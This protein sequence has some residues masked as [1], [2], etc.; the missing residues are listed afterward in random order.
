MIE[1][2]NTIQEIIEVETEA[3]KVV[4]EAIAKANELKQSVEIEIENETK[5]LVDSGKKEAATLLQAARISSEEKA[6]AFVAE[7]IKEAELMKSEAE[8]NISEVSDYI[9]H[10]LKVSYGDC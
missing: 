4:A 5:S 3:E 2:K 6:K 9:I 8:K 10:K 7:G 1:I